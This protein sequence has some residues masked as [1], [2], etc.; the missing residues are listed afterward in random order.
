MAA[1]G[2]AERRVRSQA[3]PPSAVTMEHVAL[4]K[5]HATSDDPIVA[6]NKSGAA[7]MSVVHVLKCDRLM[8]FFLASP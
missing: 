1:R 8:H 4:A 3:S 6:L 2:G 7:R 5:R